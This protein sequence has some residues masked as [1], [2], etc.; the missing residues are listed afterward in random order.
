[1][2]KPDLVVWSEKDGYDAKLKSYPTSAGGQGFDLPNVP[3]FREQSS[4]KM[5]DVFNR[6]HQEIKE[7]IEKMYDEYNTSIMVWESKISFEPIVGKSYFLYNFAGELTLSLI[8][9]NEWGRGKD[10]VGE[11]ILNSDNKWIKKNLAKNVPG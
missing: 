6:E 4:K 3:L 7:R 1:M 10:F 5:M 11:Y 8:A 9:P 2:K